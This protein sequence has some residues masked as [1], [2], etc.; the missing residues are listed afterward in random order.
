MLYFSFI[1]ALLIN[2]LLNLYLKS[3]H[4]VF[5][6]V[7]ELYR[8]KKREISLIL[9]IHTTHIKRKYVKEKLCFALT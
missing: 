5:L 4:R 6:I 1:I 3:R 7:S 8:R 9:A 2:C